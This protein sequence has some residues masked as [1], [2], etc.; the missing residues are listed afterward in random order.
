MEDYFD[1][2]KEKLD[3]AYERAEEARSKGFDPEEVPEIPLAED[4]AAR[5]EKLAGPEGVAEKIRELEDEYPREELAF[6][7]AEMIVRDEF[8]H[9]SDEDA[10]EQSIRT[11][12]AIITEGIAA[13]A[14][15][16]GITHIDIKRNFDGSSYLAIYF[17]GPIR[18]AGGTAAALAVLTG[19]FIRRKLNLDYYNPSDLEVERAVEEVN[20]YDESV[21]LQYSPTEDEVRR[22]YQ[23]IP[24][25]IT[26]EPTETETVTGHRDLERV[27]TD[28]VRGGA[29]LA[30]AEGVLQK[31]PKILKHLENL[32]ISGW[33]WLQELGKNESEEEEERK[34]PEGDKYL[35]DII[36][37]R[38]VFGY[39]DKEGG[40][41]LRYGRARNSGLAA[42]GIHPATMRIL[43]DHISVGTQLKTERPG[44][45]TAAAPVDSIE[46]PIVKLED[47]SVIQIDSP[48]RA[49][50][51]RDEVEEFLSLGDILFGYGEFLENNHPLMPSGYCEEWWAQ[52]VKE[53]LEDEEFEKDLERYVEPPFERPTPKLAVELS[54]EIGAPLHPSYTYKFHDLNLEEIKN[55]GDWLSSGM[56]EFK[57]GKITELR[58]DLDSE[59]KRLL[60][61]L[62]VP[63]RVEDEEV[64]IEEEIL[65]LTECFALVENGSLSSEKLISTIRDNQDKDSVKVMSILAGFP[66]REKAPT[67]IGS[68]VGRPEKTKPRKMSPPP[69]VLFPIGLAGGNTR[70]ISKASKKETIEIEVAH[71]ECPECGKETVLKKCPE[72]GSRTNIIRYC[73]EC[74]RE[75][76][77]E[78]CISCGTKTITYREKKIELKSLLNDS[79]GHIGESLPD[80]L[81]GVKGM[82][83]A[84]KL[85]EPLEKGILRSKNGLYVF[86]DGTVRFDATDLP[87][88]HF[89]PREVGVT[90]E[91]LKELG[92]EKDYR[93]DPLESEDQILE[94]KVQDILLPHPAADYLLRSAQFVDDLLEKF[95]ELP[96]FYNASEKD[97]LIGHLVIGLAPHTSAGI[98]GRIIGF[99]EANVGYAHPFFHAAKRRNCL[100]GNTEVFLENP[101]DLGSSSLQEIFEGN[102]GSEVVDD[103]GAEAKTVEEGHV[104]GFDWKSGE[105]SKEKVSKVYR[106][107]APKNWIEVTT[108]SGRK[109]MASP[110]HRVPTPQ[111]VKRVRELDEEDAL[112]TPEK[113]R[114][115]EEDIPRLDLLKLFEETEVKDVMV[116]GIKDFL[117]SKVNDT[118]GLKKTSER[119][120]MNKKTFS[121]YLYRDSIPVRVLK[122]LLDMTDESLS[123]V[124]PC[125]LA[126]KRD[127]VELGRWLE[128]D[129]DFMKFVGYYLAEGYSRK[130]KEKGKE[131]YQ[132]S[133]AF[134][135]ER[136]RKDMEK[137]I[138]NS[139]GLEPSVG[140]HMLTVSSRLLRELL[141]N[142]IGL[143]DGAYEKSIPFL[144]KRLP[145]KKIKPLLSAYFTGDGS[146]EKNR[147]HVCVPSVSRELL[148]DVSFLLSRFGIF[149]R[150]KTE[151]RKAGGI[152]LDKYEDKYK[153]ETFKIH[154]LSIRSSYAVK[155]GK[156]IGFSLSE[157][158][159]SL[160]KS[161]SKERKPR[162][163]KIGD[164]IVDPIKQKEIKKNEDPY[165]YDLEVE[166]THTFLTNELL[167]S[168]N[169]DGDEDAVM[170][171]LDA[172]L[173]FS[174][175]YLPETRGGKMDAP[176]VLTPKLNPS[177]IDDEAH[178]VDVE[179][180]YGKEFYEATLTYEDPGSVSS[181]IDVVEDKL[182]TTDQYENIC[183]AE[184]HDLT[185][186]SDGPR[187]CRYKSL[188]PMEDKTD[189][190]LS[191]GRKIRA[192]DESDV[193]ERLIE[194]HFIP[195]LRGNLRAFSRQEFRCPN[196]NT[197]HRRVPLSGRCS[198]CG[199]DLILTVTQGGVEKY[200]KVA[201]RVAEEFGVT[202]YTKQ[203]LGLI[204]EEIASIFESDFKEQL[205][206]ADFA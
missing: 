1:N 29:V 168:N 116:R 37:G 188:G 184:A 79:L 76:E 47:G 194:N 115:D 124:P 17:A 102:E 49:I 28:R 159:D 41:R 60:E 92:Y 39:P 83:S 185:S 100:S 101:C 155:F 152:L 55:L 16:E 43:D 129:E 85:P 169:C 58:V 172:L 62:G 146:V 110:D 114:I 177:E 59:Q 105:Q 65:P 5:V 42:A 95:Y 189:S 34:Y 137:I 33:D 15:I 81:K 122:D 40:F 123:E 72:C 195:D 35:G 144:F 180:E 45:A 13:A 97:D 176:L 109:M 111:G 162:I 88:T 22:A 178:N 206:L 86:K 151:E 12:L 140:D 69:H 113:I 108:Q 24:V 179:E 75:M 74:D 150:V 182:G 170:L 143:G 183:F 191:L 204:E 201:S 87:L 26:G 68:R 20:I 25:E 66:I 78:E 44:K 120:G 21:G 157:K 135:D 126:A 32:G 57:N 36:A 198:N 141:V 90:V 89:R 73:P 82:M 80:T 71:C 63:H 161:Y 187:K 103:F 51:L 200:M 205:S 48:T 186:I 132:I 142:I 164:L 117:E 158:Q 121:N 203:R 112:F 165:M 147:L 107:P 18:S 167:L 9:L 11:C 3:E 128:I 199:G 175:Y 130:S 31:A 118:G 84:Y 139:F 8:G 14:P 10:A 2:L 23:N 136:V 127:S 174:R 38:P 171:L 61:I 19:D 27:E 192:V 91:R 148:K 163:Q 70:N 7:I 125:K 173:N 94:L 98:T 56:P 30:I 77:E 154:H 181:E 134:G 93:G 202:N 106:M 46:G 193:A 67:R 166:N 52:E 50:E 190:Q 64:I 4:L 99:S 96:P 153:N 138:K 145:K 54:R 6:K 156:E 131:F 119:L 149:S 104:L 197:K 133:L 53:A 196:C 160:E